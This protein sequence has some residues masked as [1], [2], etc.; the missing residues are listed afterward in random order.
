MHGLRHTSITTLI[1]SCVPIK[2]VSQRAGH[3]SIATTERI[4]D[5]AI[6][7]ADAK[8]GEV[9]DEVIAKKLEEK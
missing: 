2:A 1:D 8:M 7:V 9:L 5:H 6:R 4:Y 3:A